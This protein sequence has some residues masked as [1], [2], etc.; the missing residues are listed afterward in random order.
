MATLHILLDTP[1]RGAYLR[2]TEEFFL[3]NGVKSD[4]QNVW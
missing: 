2:P 3:E 1:K 4:L